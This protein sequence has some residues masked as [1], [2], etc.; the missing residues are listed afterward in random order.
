MTQNPILTPTEYDALCNVLEWVWTS[1]HQEP[2]LCLKDVNYS[3]ASKVVSETRS[4]T[5][6]S[7]EYEPTGIDP[8]KT[9][10]C[11]LGLAEAFE[12]TLNEPN[13]LNVMTMIETLM[14]KL[15]CNPCLAN[16]LG[17]TWE[18]LAPLVDNTERDRLEETSDDPDITTQTLEGYLIESIGLKNKV[19]RLQE[20]FEDV[21][22]NGL[23][24]LDNNLWIDGGNSD[25][26]P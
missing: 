8:I 26:F 5:G 7:V 2:E 22:E 11:G 16:G 15:N 21:G 14:Y 19:A 9:G 3:S 6:L 23:I 10:E 24:E 4:E 18:T 17:N 12:Y 1:L 13:Q 25:I 20:H